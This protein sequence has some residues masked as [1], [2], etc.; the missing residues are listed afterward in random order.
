MHCKHPENKN[1]ER[2][3][4]L[5]KMKMRK[6][7]NPEDCILVTETLH[8]NESLQFVKATFD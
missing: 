2:P 6:E 1:T 3:E 4:W 7:L 8:N 5:K